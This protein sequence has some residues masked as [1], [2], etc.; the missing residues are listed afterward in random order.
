MLYFI[1][2]KDVVMEKQPN[3]GMVLKGHESSCYFLLHFCIIRQVELSKI[4][5]KKYNG[6]SDEKKAK[7]LEIAKKQ[8]EDYQEKMKKFMYVFRIK[9]LFD[10]YNPFAMFLNIRDAHPDYVPPKSKSAK[11]VAPRPPTPFNLFS[12]DKMEE[13]LAEGVTLSDAR[14]VLGLYSS[15]S[16]F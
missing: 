4:I 1:E 14:F 6:L 13:L 16:A 8:M 5:A 15:F 9:K 3:L 10:I 11:A 7:Y 12:D 2:Q